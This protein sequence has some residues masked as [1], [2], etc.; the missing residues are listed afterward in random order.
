ML[1]ADFEM[2][3]QQLVIEAV[4]VLASCLEE[5]VEHEAGFTIRSMQARL[6]LMDLVEE[7]SA[8]AWLGLNLVKE[9]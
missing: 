6:L 7:V 8:S 5:A 1:A 3:L 2:M 9:A 4:A